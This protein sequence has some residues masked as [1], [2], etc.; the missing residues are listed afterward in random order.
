MKAEETAKRL[1][2][3][4]PW[5]YGQ[6]QDGKHEHEQDDAEAAAAKRVGGHK[7]SK[8]A[9]RQKRRQVQAQQETSAAAAK[10]PVSTPAPVP[11]SAP[12]AAPSVSLSGEQKDAMRAAVYGCKSMLITGGAGTGKSVL[13]RTIVRQLRQMYP[14]EGIAVTATTGIAGLNIRGQTIHSWAGIG[15]GTRTVSDLVEH[16][17]KRRY[18]VKRWERV[19]VL[20]IDEVSMLDAALFD[21]LEGIARAVRRD[22]RPFGGIQLI[23][24]GDFFQLPP[25]SQRTPEGLVCPGEYRSNFAFDARTWNDCVSQTVVLTEVFRQA[26]EDLVHALNQLRIGQV[27]PD[28]ERFFVNLSRDI[29]CSDGI[30]PTELF[31]R[32]AEVERANQSRLAALHGIPHTYDAIDMV[33]D[34]FIAKSD[35]ERRKIRGLRLSELAK[36]TIAP[37]RIEL[38]IGA[39]V[40]LTKNLNE[41]LVNGSCGVVIGFARLEREQGDAPVRSNPGSPPPA[42]ATDDTSSNASSSAIKDESDQGE[43]EAKPDTTRA[44]AG[45]VDLADASSLPLFATQLPR[46]IS[47][48]KESR[49][50]VEWPVVRFSKGLASDEKI[51]KLLTPEKFELES[52]TPGEFDAARIQVGALRVSESMCEPELLTI[53]LEQVPLILAW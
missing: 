43:T 35:E 33:Y 11:V 8:R 19:E 7:R 21:K 31:P 53:S 24:C 13:L 36:S 30:M 27:T 37:A 14:K 20:V 40:M 29:D 42:D 4:N 44:K 45:Y 3:F 2:R 38:C 46:R 52:S 49:Y 18:L 16:I 26:E 15:F 23:L 6:P 1:A 47:A 25:V 34:N 32:K 41:D 48:D 50:D 5:L 22:Q 10:E 39:Q 51:V 12:V 9:R 17:R 28:V